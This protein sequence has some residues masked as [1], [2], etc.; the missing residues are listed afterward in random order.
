MKKLILIS[1]IAILAFSCKKEEVTSST[2]HTW[3][4]TVENNYYFSGII[5]DTTNFNSLVNS[6]LIC[7]SCNICIMDTINDS[8]YFLQIRTYTGSKITCDGNP[9]IKIINSSDSVINRQ[10]IPKSSWIKNDT[11]SYNLYF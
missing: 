2:T 8:T 11:V 6:I 1:V 3:G 4:Q 7:Y 5:K 10:Y 9:Q